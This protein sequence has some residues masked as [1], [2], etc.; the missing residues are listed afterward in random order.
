[1]FHKNNII[2]L[3]IM[4]DGLKMSVSTGIRITI[5]SVCFFLVYLFQTANAAYDSFMDYHKFS[6]VI[7]QACTN[8]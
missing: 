1:M 2:K 7:A 5:T 8:N 4:D 3:I 6:A